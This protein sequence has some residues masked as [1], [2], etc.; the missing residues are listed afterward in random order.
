VKCEDPKTINAWFQRIQE[1]R[2]LY[3]IDDEDVYNFNETGFMMGIIMTCKV[4]IGSDTIRRAI[5]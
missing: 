2:L 3:S 4:V 5:T 1:T